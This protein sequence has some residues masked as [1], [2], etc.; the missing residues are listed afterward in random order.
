[1]ADLGSIE[2]IL[3]QILSALGGSNGYGMPNSALI[4]GR[5]VGHAYDQ[6]QRAVQQDAYTTPFA[7]RILQMGGAKVY[8]NTLRTLGYSNEAAYKQAFMSNETGAHTAR[9]LGAMWVDKQAGE[10]I[11]Q[12]AIASYEAMR[13]FHTRGSQGYRDLGHSFAIAGQEIFKGVSTG[14]L[15]AYTLNEAYQMGS[16]LMSSGKYSSISDSR[17]RVNNIKRDLKQYASG[18]ADLKDALGGSLDDVLT[19]FEALAG[20]SAAAV[21]S[22]RFKNIARSL[23]QT[24]TYGRASNELIQS[25]VAAQHSMY[26]GTGLMQSASVA[27]GL[28]NANVLAHGVH[29]EGANADYMS[30]GMMEQNQMW[31]SSGRRKEL[32]AAFSYYADKKGIEQNQENFKKFL[33]TELN[34]QA[35]AEAVSN[36]LKNNQVRGDYINS[37][38]VLRSASSPFLDEAMWLD[39][40]TQAKSN[41]KATFMAM[42]ESNDPRVM[43]DPLYGIVRKEDIGL[44]FETFRSQIQQR[45]YD[46]WRK[47]PNY[48]EESDE[49]LRIRAAQEADRAENMFKDVYRKIAPHMDVNNTKNLVDN[50]GSTLQDRSEY[51]TEAAK[52]ELANTTTIKGM[53]G[54]FT[55]MIQ[56]DNGVATV[57]KILSGAYG[58]TMNP[59]LE[60]KLKEIQKLKDHPELAAVAMEDFVQTAAKS[61]G[62][63]E[64]V[65]GEEYISYDDFA[66]KGAEN[67][68]KMRSLSNLDKK[69]LAPI[70]DKKGKDISND[71]GFE[72]IGWHADAG[73]NKELL[74]RA[75][76]AKGRLLANQ[77][78]NEKEREGDVLRL[79]VGIGQA[80]ELGQLTAEEAFVYKQEALDGNW[81][82]RTKEE[83]S[84]IIG[85]FRMAT[86]LGYDAE[87]ATKMADTVKKITMNPTG[88]QENKEARTQLV[89]SI[90]NSKN[91]QSMFGKVGKDVQ[92]RIA[93][94]Q[95]SG[96]LGDK[97]GALNQEQIL[98]KIMADVST[99]ATK[100]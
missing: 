67:V 53:A 3:S 78:K 97:Q 99:L 25:A 17:Q 69:L 80:V 60:D 26:Q 59:E 27:S 38:H 98:M 34:G 65:L 86:D 30:Q 100:K 83:K 40:H 45:L 84:K 51:K 54:V 89:E 46:R 52:Q 96:L 21:G 87:S 71:R 18:I 9:Q 24:T 41:Y 82:V 94:S 61:T 11:R 57:G 42:N 15:G 93:M 49:T 1:M 62:A 68:S 85:A 91:F 74:G 4:A 23:Y 20:N 88:S 75:V 44:D 22:A 47:D 31:V 19:Q 7:D 56:H 92:E 16:H 36:Y 43:R 72:T 13:R 29:I 90:K 39:V 63:G 58:V 8:E 6:Y 33:N 64:V 35:S 10:G 76:E 2:H 95:A 70:I 5:S 81:G 77:Y 73:T 14:E 37:D 12:Y 50:L 79:R 32:A 28:F 48:V 66:K 55:K